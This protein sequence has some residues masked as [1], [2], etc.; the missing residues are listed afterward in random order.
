[1]GTLLALLIGHWYISGHALDERWYQ[2][3]MG[4]AVNL[5][6]TGHFG[7]IRLVSDATEADRAGLNE[8]DEFLH[9]RQLDYTCKSFPRV[10]PNTIFDGIDPNNAEQ[11]YYLVLIYGLIWRLFGVHWAAT[12]YVVSGVIALSFLAIYFCARQFTPQIVAASGALLFLICPVFITNIVSPRDALKFPFA[13]AIAGLLIGTGTIL[14]TPIRFLLFACMIGGLIGIG[15]GFRSDL[16]LFLMPAILIIAM[17]GKPELCASKASRLN[18][19]VSN[20]GIRLAAASAVLFA[21]CIGACLPL[22]NDLIFS[23]HSLDGGYHVLAMGFYG[24]TNYSLY[25]SNSPN[26]EMYMY[27]NNFGGDEPAAMRIME[28]ALRRDGKNVRAGS[29]AYWPY[30]KQYFFHVSRQVPA[31]LLS[32]GIGSFVNLMS[33]PASL[34]KNPPQVSNFDTSAPWG[35]A[36]YFA[37]DYWIIK[38]LVAPLDRLYAAATNLPT[39]YWFYANVIVLFW[40]L[41]LLGGRF[42]PR[43]VVAAV[44]LIWVVLAVT[45][46]KFEMRHMFY[47]YTLSLVAWM[48]VI[49]SLV[50]GLHSL[51]PV[52]N[53]RVLGISEIGGALLNK[54]S[55]AAS[56]LLPVAVIAL[57]TMDLTFAALLGARIYQINALRA[58]TADL[59]S[60]PRLAA[61]YEASDQPP[62]PLDVRVIPPGNSRIKIISPMPLSTG[63]YLSANP[64]EETVQMGVVAVTIDGHACHNRLVTLTG[65]GDYAPLRFKTVGTVSQLRTAALLHETFTI[66]LR[67]PHRYLAF[68]PAFYFT[69]NSEPKLDM[70]F[71][72]LDLQKNDVP[73]ISKIEF[74]TKFNREDVLFDFFLPEDPALLSN[75]DLFQRVEIPGLGFL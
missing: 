45:S 69:K 62:G 40:F 43:S 60:R 28:Y 67:N 75:T 48:G 17:C 46:L 70:F 61:S 16:L 29:D 58:I 37:H 64:P 19:A 6:C 11:P 44:V 50:R 22:S 9:V 21:F 42:G 66:R 68:F 56:I 36:Y 39:A 47:I 59:I 31:D 26:E 63:G 5:A 30:A 65:I 57:A 24:R 25:Q 53:E 13:V 7:P 41:C 33:L 73:C 49:C 18:R 32:R 74:V 14:R 71:A 1:V 10:L 20:C 34:A 4:A 8:I 2:T 35:N 52:V 15:Y 27:R 3:Y 55:A 72:G 12:Y 51:L 54:A 38:R 23:K